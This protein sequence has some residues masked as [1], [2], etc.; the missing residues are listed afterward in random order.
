VGCAHPYTFQKE[1]LQIG[2]RSGVS[3]ASMTPQARRDRASPTKQGE[4]QEYMSFPSLESPYRISSA[5]I[6]NPIHACLLRV[7]KP[8]VLIQLM[9][10]PWY[11]SGAKQNM[12]LLSSFK[13]D[14]AS[15][16]FR[17]RLQRCPQSALRICRVMRTTTAMM[18]VPHLT[19]VHANR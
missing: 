14:P 5:S 13:R 19:F 15:Q 3:L 4:H 9:P 7:T 6:V 12:D 17:R 10:G 8:V 16:K 11:W 1:V 2:P 18:V